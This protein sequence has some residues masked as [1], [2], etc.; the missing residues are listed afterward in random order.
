LFGGQDNALHHS[1]GTTLSA[2]ASVISGSRPSV[3]ATFR[4]RRS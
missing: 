2:T 3:M 1:S 4:V